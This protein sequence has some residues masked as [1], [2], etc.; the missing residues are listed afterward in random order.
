MA[1]TALGVGLVIWF[2]VRVDWTD[3]GLGTPGWPSLLVTI[4]SFGLAGALLVDRRPDLPFGWLLSAAAFGQVL[5]AATALPALAAA[6]DGSDSTLVGWGLA[7]TLGFLPI[8]VQGIVYVRFPTGK[9][10]TKRGR[11]LEV[12]IIAGTA[13]VLFGGLFDPISTT[14]RQ[15]SQP[16]SSTH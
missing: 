3:D 15:T 4:I 7:S 11:V 14:L 8:A 12:G 1:I 6:R 10:A 2:A 5:Y 16:G 13:L 9:P